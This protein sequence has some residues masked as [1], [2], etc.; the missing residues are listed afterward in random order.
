[1]TLGADVVQ[2]QVR[3]PFWL[4]YPPVS[5]ERSYLSLAKSVS[6]LAVLVIYSKKPKSFMY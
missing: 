3:R 6:C 5:L 2:Q 1:M 4:V